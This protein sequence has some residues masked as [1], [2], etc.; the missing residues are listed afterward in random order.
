MNNDFEKMVKQSNDATLL[1]MYSNEA[2]YTE[3]RREIL[4]NELKIR[5]LS[6]IT[7]FEISKKYDLDYGDFLDFLT[8]NNLEIEKGNAPFER[9]I[10]TENIKKYVS[11][12]TGEPIE[13]IKPVS[14]NKKE[15]KK[16]D[17]DSKDCITN[18]SVLPENNHKQSTIVT[19]SVSA[20]DIDIVLSIASIRRMGL[21]SIICAILNPI[22]TLICG[23]IGKRRGYELHSVPSELK[24]SLNE[25]IGYNQKG[26]TLSIVFLVIDIIAAIIATVY[27]GGYY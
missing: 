8:D 25:A 21:I 18:S 17:T 26:I 23:S 27:F 2:Y 6:T 15:K 5:G 9:S 16:G 24:A 13:N 19:N 22:I 1:D 3:E 11:M 7:I 10:K 14:V 12:Y 4:Q 20:K